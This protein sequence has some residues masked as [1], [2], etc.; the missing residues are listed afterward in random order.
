M[1]NLAEVRAIFPDGP[2][3]PIEIHYDTMK[4]LILLFRQMCLVSKELRV[5]SGRRRMLTHTVRTLCL[6]SPSYPQSSTML[7]ETNRHE[8]YRTTPAGPMYIP[9]K[10]GVRISLAASP[11]SSEALCKSGRD[12]EQA[13]QFA[14]PQNACLPREG[15]QHSA[16][17]CGHGGSETREPL[18][19]HNLCTHEQW[20]L[21]GRPAGRPAMPNSTAHHARLDNP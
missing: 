16:Q 21:T 2:H 10:D 15:R 14:D 18:Q 20:R 4:C 5:T 8:S 1:P 12:T 11:G 19:D 9:Q 13:G 17:H 7:P 3:T 6:E